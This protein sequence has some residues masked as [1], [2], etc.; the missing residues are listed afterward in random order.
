MFQ[1][2]GEENTGP[3]KAVNNPQNTIFFLNI[4]KT[5]K[6]P[7]KYPDICE[8]VYSGRINLY[9]A[10]KLGTSCFCCPRRKLNIA[11]LKHIKSRSILC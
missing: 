11:P 6:Y 2:N 1:E 7:Q 9:E 10:L 5:S 3:K 4:S 8:K